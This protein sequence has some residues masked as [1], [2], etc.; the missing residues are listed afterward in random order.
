MMP[1]VPISDGTTVRMDTRV[2][3]AADEKN[4]ANCNASLAD[5]ALRVL[6]AG[7]APLGPTELEALRACDT[8]EA[9]LQYLKDQQKACFMGLLGNADPP[10]P[11]VGD[12]I[13]TCQ[14][15]GVRVVMITG[16]QKP[17]AVAIAR[18]IR[19]LGQDEDPEQTVLVCAQLRD[20]QN[21]LKPDSELD[22]ICAR[23]NVFSRAQPEDKIAIVHSLQR[24]GQVC[25]M[26]GDGVNDAPALKAA[27]IGV[28]M[29][30]AGTDVAKGA[31][32]MVLLDDNFCTI[33]AAV[34]EG[35]KIYANIQ[36]FV[37][38]LL[39][40]NIGEVIY[41]SISI[42][43]SLPVPLEALQIIFLNLMSDGCP[44][45]ALSKEPSDPDNMNV[46]PRDKKSNIMTKHWWLYGNF[47]HVFFEAMMVLCSLSLNLYLF[48]GQITIP[49]IS[50]NCYNAWEEEDVSPL[51][52][53]CI[54][55]RWQF[56]ENDWATVVDWYKPAS[57]LPGTARWGKW[58]GDGEVQY[59]GKLTKQEAFDQWSRDSS[60]GDKMSWIFSSPPNAQGVRT[61]LPYPP[62]TW[63]HV[64][65]THWQGAPD[66]EQNVLDPMRKELEDYQDEDSYADESCVAIGTKL[67]RSVTF[68]TA[69]YC[70]M[71]RAYTVR[72]APGSGQNP[73]WMWEVFMRN[74][75]M[76]IACSISFW[77][78]I[79]ITCVDQHIIEGGIF[80]LAR[81]PFAAFFIG[82]AFAIVNAI[83]DEFTAKPL[84]KALVIAPMMKLRGEKGQGGDEKVQESGADVYTAVKIE[85]ET[86]EAVV[87]NQP[88]APVEKKYN[89]ASI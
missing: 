81:P 58:Y 7:V 17:T 79:L 50:D 12:A 78:T 45:V 44:A 13:K 37:S 74:G 75:W 68:L 61:V 20:S 86:G 85:T 46:A 16:D 55:H 33:V 5:N 11:G 10:R 84:Y 40:T 64:I 67:G 63:E 53:V 83:C 62:T 24:Q 34:E 2:R 22:P 3:S 9:R 71:M 28:A 48:T 54:C 6:A 49:Q 80:H 59:A 41:L 29:G 65:L 82:I 35:R 70:E 77:L 87:T 31:A 38:F 25:A 56:S 88:P 8:A 76:H 21:N 4:I 23:I 72:C 15:A 43:C 39:G 36:K 52:L 57:Q 69:V 19:L 66:R 26:T 32:D 42:I 27:D 18:Q 51:P 14:S 89:E 73:Q 1:Y 47:P 60:L 30:I